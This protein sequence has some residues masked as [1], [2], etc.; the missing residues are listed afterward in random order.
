MDRLLR[1][2]QAI[3]YVSFGV[4]PVLSHSNYPTGPCVHLRVLTQHIIVLGSVDAASELLEKRSAHYSSRPRLVSYHR[5]SVPSLK[6]NSSLDY[7][8]HGG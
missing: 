1:V 6:S 3:R 7:L 2:S 4:K 8:G 5:G